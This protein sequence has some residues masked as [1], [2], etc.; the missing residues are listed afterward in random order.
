[1]SRSSMKIATVR[2]CT[3]VHIYMYMHTVK[4]I[5]VV[6]VHLQYNY[7]GNGNRSCPHLESNLH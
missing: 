6:H 1:M 2:P 3:P 7:G 4:Y 5:H